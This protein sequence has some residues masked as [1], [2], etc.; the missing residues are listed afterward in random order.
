MLTSE[1]MLD[2]AQRVKA[3]GLVVRAELTHGLEQDLR[4]RDLLD[5]AEQLEARGPRFFAGS[6]FGKEIME[7]KGSTVTLPKGTRIWG[8]PPSKCDSDQDFY[9]T[10]RDLQL[11]VR[12][13][14][15]GYFSSGDIRD[16]SL[17]F[18]GAGGGWSFVDANDIAEAQEIYDRL[19]PI[20]SL[21]VPDPVRTQRQSDL[22]DDIDALG[23]APRP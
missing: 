9:T 19:P 4:E 11:S 2:L 14:S 6:L 16:P 1:M 13:V 21:L 7:L 18:S 23:S 10:K 20:D 5:L 22:P 15:T 17:C 3:Q 12:R 8:Y